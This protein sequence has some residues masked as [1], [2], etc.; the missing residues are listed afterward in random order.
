VNPVRLLYIDDDP[1]LVRL[2]Q[3][4]L[5]RRGYAVETA[6]DGEQGLARIH[7][8]GID[9]V[10]LDHYM[11]GQDGLETLAR[12][13]DLAD[14]PPVIYVTGTNESSVA[15]AALKA[16]AADYVVK[17][18]HKDFY[19]LLD[20]AIRSAMEST[21]LRRAK[22]AA[23][24][25]IKEARDRFEALATERQVLMREVNHRVGNSL[26]LVAAFLH[27][28]A[29]SSANETRAA[30]AEANRRVL[31]IA[32]VHRRLY[33]SDDVKV[34][35]LHQYLAGLV[36]DIRQSADQEGTAAQL[37]LRADEVDIDPDNAVTIGIIVTELVINAMKYAYPGG[38]GPIRVLLH[39]AGETQCRLSVEDEGVGKA[40]DAPRSRTG[41]G[42]SIIKA[43]ATKLGT[44]V[45]Y[46][47]D[48]PGTQATLVFS[49]AAPDPD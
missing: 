19:D 5:T 41:I 43:M 15:V 48:G 1:A 46:R 9:A 32:Q 11:P 34:V 35:A 26:Q 23:E 16:G 4:E 28:Q 45:D 13:R 17:D 31:A 6:S 18:V 49:T 2:I 24:R 36:D 22:A 40:A 7:S 27:M 10:A 20:A 39:K 12:I 44:T 25:D 47:Q 42:R 21:G 29:S 33:S 14:P 3:R 30:L 38:H 8:G 37:S